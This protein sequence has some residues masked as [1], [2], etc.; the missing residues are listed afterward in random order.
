MG[1]GTGEGGREIK[2]EAALAIE[3]ESKVLE[4]GRLNCWVWVWTQ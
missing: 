2:A 4:D 3:S 1:R